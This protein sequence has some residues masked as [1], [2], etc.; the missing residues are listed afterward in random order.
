MREM[1]PGIS[2][3]I[4]ILGDFNTDWTTDGSALKSIVEN[5]GLR[6]FQPDSTELG[7]YKKGRDRLDWILISE[8]LEF[9]SY[10]VPQQILS[11]HQPVKASLRLVDNPAPAGDSNAHD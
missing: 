11:D 7:T 2:K 5:G 3:P 6:V 4:I 9:V 10:E 8:D 1:L